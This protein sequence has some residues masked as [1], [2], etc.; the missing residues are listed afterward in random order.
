[1]SHRASTRSTARFFESS[2]L[3]RSAHLRKSVATRTRE[4]RAGLQDPFRRLKSVAT[5]DFRRGNGRRTRRTRR[6]RVRLSRDFD[7]TPHGQAQR[8]TKSTRPS[9]MHAARTHSTRE[10]ARKTVEPTSATARLRHSRTHRRSRTSSR[11]SEPSAQPKGVSHHLE[12]PAEQGK[13]VAVLR[14]HG[15]SWQ[16]VRSRPGMRSAGRLGTTLAA[17]SRSC[18]TPPRLA[19]TPPRAP[20]ETLVVTPDA[21]LRRGSRNPQE[22][23][24]N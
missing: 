16:S 18:T 19:T 17:R 13:K 12:G 24:V 3:K 23:E 9:I 22:E 6:S 7:V 15:S 21:G 20:D 11:R 14:R 2:R 8:T 1:M 4:S 5:I 10:R